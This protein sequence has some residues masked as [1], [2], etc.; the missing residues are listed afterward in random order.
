MDFLQAWEENKKEMRKAD[1]GMWATGDE[2]SN[3]Y[4]LLDDFDFEQLLFLGEEGVEDARGT[5]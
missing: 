4:E 5:F 2:E 1:V 3:G